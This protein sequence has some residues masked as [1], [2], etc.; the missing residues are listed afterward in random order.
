MRILLTG[1]T[2]FTGRTL[3]PMLRAA[4][5]DVF[6]IVR[7]E[8]EAAQDVLWDLSAP[9]P[10]DLPSFNILIHLAAHVDFGRDLDPILYRV[11]TVSTMSLARAARERRACFI[12]AS[13]V[14][15]HG[16]DQT[17]IDENVSVSPTTHYAMS[18]YLAEEAVKSQE[19]PY[20]I[21]RIGGI[22][23]L[24]GPSH[25]G[26][27][28]AISAAFHR[29]ERPVLRGP[30]KARRNYICVVD[31]ARWINHLVTCQESLPHGSSGPAETLYLAGPEVFSIE[32]Y[33][34]QIVDLMLPGKEILRQEGAESSDSIIQATPFPFEPL[35]FRQYIRSLRTADGHRET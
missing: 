35:T 29:G 34:E 4:G 8:K 20:S 15:V 23:G 9:C 2:G 19:I 30:G 12:L 33:L 5:H 18:K 28:R 25:L 14:G 17:C 26:L 31:V 21:L 11:N 7:S 22:Y 10:S 13:M 6:C 27:N 32:E 1:G 24:D 3:M 16:T